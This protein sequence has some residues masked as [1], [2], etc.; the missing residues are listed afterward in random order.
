[1]PT[2]SAPWPCPGGGPVV[3]G[4]G[5][6]GADIATSL[7]AMGLAVTRLTDS[8]ALAVV[9]AGDRRIVHTPEA[10]LEADLV[11]DA[12]GSI[13]RTR[14][15]ETAGLDVD[16]GVLVDA[17]GRTADERIGAAGAVAHRVDPV[18]GSLPGRLGRGERRGVRGR[19]RALARRPSRV[20][21]R[22]SRVSRHDAQ[23]T[24]PGGEFPPS[25]CFTC[26]SA[27][28]TVGA[29]TTTT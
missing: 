22:P 24:T 5:R 21:G 6:S 12:R 29:S 19:R 2:R 13:P 15:A 28:P 8:R 7:A 26:A 25:R 3:V 20:A 4:A 1:M 10:T 14:L 17:W 18:V 9:K 11:V 16:Q 23:F 27:A